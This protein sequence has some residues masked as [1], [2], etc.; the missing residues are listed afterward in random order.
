M[1]FKLEMFSDFVCPFCYIG[2]ATVRK[3]QPEFD[4]E[5]EPRAFQI[6]PEWPA[7]GLPLAQHPRMMDPKARR[8]IWTHILELADAAGVTMKAPEVLANSRLALQAAEFA[9]ENGRGEAFD[10]LVYRAY[11]S[12]GLNIGLQGVL[13]DLATAVGLDRSELD[14]ALE[15]QRYAAR[16][17]RDSQLAHQRGVNGVPA[18]FLG[19]FSIVGA[20]S[21]EMMRAVIRR[22]VARTDAAK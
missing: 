1:A 21:A 8:L 10:D 19:E 17:E 16:L 13:G 7:E 3:L 15:S 18:F 11:F 20:Q 6:H 2:L 4:F 5:L 14:R 12:D 22:Y 9:R